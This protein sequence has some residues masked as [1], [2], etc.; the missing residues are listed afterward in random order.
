[1]SQQKHR[2]ADA[3][4]WRAMPNR[5]EMKEEMGYSEASKMR[6]LMMASAYNTMLRSQ[7]KPMPNPIWM[8]FADRCQQVV[9]SEE[10]M[11]NLLKYHTD[12]A[13]VMVVRYW[14][15]NCT[16]C[17][18]L[19]KVTEFLCRE[20]KRNY[21][22]LRFYQVQKETQPTLVTGMVRFPQ[23]KAFSGGQWADIDH[24]PPEYH[25]QETYKRVAQ[26][27]QRMSDLGTPIDALQAEEMYFS[28]SGPAIAT[29]VNESVTDFYL[30]AQARMHNYWKQVSVRR[31]WFFRKYIEPQAPKGS[32]EASQYF[33]VFGERVDPPPSTASDNSPPEAVPTP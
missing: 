27:V 2:L 4:G 25:R 6:E 13:D 28:A 26:E 31:T 23:M 9:E 21:P 22:N 24:K 19:D 17:N 30:K 15:E 20:A 12:S 10:H 14:Q 16:A 33:S 5:K 11:R 18:A 7:E 29:V 3:D 8:D 1:M 32:A